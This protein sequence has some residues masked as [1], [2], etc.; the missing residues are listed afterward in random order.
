MKGE[1]MV[2]KNCGNSEFTSGI[3]E[4]VAFTPSTEKRKLLSTGIYG[5]EAVVCVKCGQIINLSLDIN[6]L[7]KVLKLD[8]SK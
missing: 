5:I 4:G 1:E 2:C 7:N 6:A 3:L 8:K